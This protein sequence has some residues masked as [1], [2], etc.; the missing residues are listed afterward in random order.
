MVAFA[1][2][3]WGAGSPVSSTPPPGGRSRGPWGPGDHQTATRA[4]P[5]SSSRLSWWS[6]LEFFLDS[7]VGCSHGSLARV[8]A[9]TPGARRLGTESFIS[10]PQLKR[11]PLDGR[12]WRN[13]D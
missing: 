5:R 10:A 1:R 8:G 13:D 3:H 7:L 11:G 12:M 6:S 2:P 4:W 9:L